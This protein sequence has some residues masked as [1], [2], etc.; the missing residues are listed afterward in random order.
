MER[1][2]LLPGVNFLER[3]DI[4]EGGAW[5]YLLLRVHTASF[6]ISRRRLNDGLQRIRKTRGLP[7]FFFDFL[8]Y[9]FL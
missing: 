4:L 8:L 1:G 5:V 9:F 2:M 7:C 6:F 3:V